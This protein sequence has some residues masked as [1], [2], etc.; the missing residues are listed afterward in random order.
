MARKQEHQNITQQHPDSK[1]DCKSICIAVVQQYC[2]SPMT[3]LQYADK[4]LPDPQ[5]P[6]PPTAPFTLKG[7][8]GTVCD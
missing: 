5:H 6:A 3:L 2:T 7:P 4:S 8:K 1:V